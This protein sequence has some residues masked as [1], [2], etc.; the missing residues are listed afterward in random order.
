MR[1]E[2]ALL[3]E[4]AKE[5]GSITNEQKTA[6]INKAKQL[7]VDPVEVANQLESIPLS[8]SSAI[9]NDKESHQSA[10]LHY[11]DIKRCPNCGAVVSD[12][13]GKC[14][15]CGYVFNN[16]HVIDSYSSLRENII[17]YQD[18]LVASG[19][20]IVYQKLATFIR[21]LP[22]PSSKADIIELMLVCSANLFDPN[23]G[24]D[25][26]AKVEERIIRGEALYANDPQVVQSIQYAKALLKQ[27]NRRV[28]FRNETF[29]AQVREQQNIERQELNEQRKRVIWLLLLLSVIM[30]IVAIF[31]D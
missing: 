20:T 21:T 2:I 12:Y 25:Y 5:S 1:E 24:D 30:A 6:I 27:Q 11:G 28:T 22:V 14:L 15:D 19:S 31:A 29:S 26:R 3:I 7:G 4:F 10:S 18:D 23:N 16:V 9:E 17:K 13:I 8:D